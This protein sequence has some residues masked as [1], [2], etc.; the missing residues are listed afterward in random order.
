MTRQKLRVLS[1]NRNRVVEPN[2]RQ[3]VE[4]KLGRMKQNKKLRQEQLTLVKVRSNPEVQK[5]KMQRLKQVKVKLKQMVLQVQTQI[6]KP[7]LK[8]KLMIK[9]DT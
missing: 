7:T 5:V 9:R 6:L 2:Q 1:L 3:Q 4:I 8:L